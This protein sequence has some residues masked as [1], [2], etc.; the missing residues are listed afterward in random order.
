MQLTQLSKLRLM[1]NCHCAQI[2]KYGHDR[3]CEKG[4]K[5]IPNFWQSLAMNRSGYLPHVLVL[6]PT[7][8]RTFPVTLCNHLHS[9]HAQAGPWLVFDSYSKI[10]INTS[11]QN[12]CSMIA[13]NL[14]RA[15][16][17]QSSTSYW[18]INSEPLCHHNDKGPFCTI[19]LPHGGSRVS[20]LVVLL[21]NH[22]YSAQFCRIALQ[23]GKQRTEEWA[24]TY[25]SPQFG[26]YATASLPSAL[27]PT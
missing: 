27:P 8:R 22:I 7:Q 2:Y 9:I 5:G 12:I 13:M 25:H 20:T 1:L 11:Q 14:V 10:Q 6:L 21:L 24:N 16:G 18:S 4:N 26:S 17:L 23:E 19:L 3:D 15:T